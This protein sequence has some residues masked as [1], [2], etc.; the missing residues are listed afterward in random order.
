MGR[1]RYLLDGEAAATGI[2][3]E[4]LSDEALAGP[5]TPG[6]EDRPVCGDPAAL[7]ELE[8]LLLA[9]IPGG[10]IVEPLDRSGAVLKATLSRAVSFRFCR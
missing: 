5:G 10:A 8:E 2:L 3:A 1:R 4:S 7:G 9:Q 6:D